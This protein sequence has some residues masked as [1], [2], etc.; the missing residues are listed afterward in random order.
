MR[1]LCVLT[2]LM[3]LFLGSGPVFAQRYAILASNNRGWTGDSPLRF[4]HQ[5][6]NRIA[7]TLREMGGFSTKNIQILEGATPQS[8]TGA[9]KKVSAKMR[10]EAKENRESLLFFFFSGHGDEKSLHLG[11]NALSY[12]KIKSL[13]YGCPAGVR[14]VILDSCNSGAITQKGAQAGPS[15]VIQDHQPL[16]VKG[17]IFLSAASRSELSQ[18]S[19]FLKGSFFATYLNTGLRGAADANKD[20]TVTLSE[21]YDFTYQMTVSRTSETL[22]GTQHPAYR[23]NIQGKGQIVLT[24]LKKDRTGLIIGRKARN[25]RYLVI[26]DPDQAVVAEVPSSQTHDTFISLPAGKYRIRRWTPKGPEEQTIKIALNQRHK[27]ND[28]LMHRIEIAEAL[29]KGGAGDQDDEY[30]S[31]RKI[32]WAAIGVGGASLITGIVFSVM[33]R[34]KALEYKE[35]A[36]RDENYAVLTEIDR[37]GKRYNTIQLATLIAGGALTAGGVGM[38]VWDWIAKRRRRRARR[39]IAF[40]PL[41]HQGAWGMAGAWTF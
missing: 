33:A 29:T 14:I 37:A 15:F 35:A 3:M 26:H 41:M 27:L 22:S 19:K 16:S 8:I 38:L 13:I 10:Q 1:R 17:E 40:R 7:Y 34:Q 30:W 2:L 21:V 11:A 18:E 28:T 9:F 5:D 23:F 24:K 36:E 39:L 32:G 12:Q 4:A 6:I 25:H 20:G 31:K